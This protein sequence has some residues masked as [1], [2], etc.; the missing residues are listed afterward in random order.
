MIAGPVAVDDTVAKSV[1]QLLL[2]DKNYL[3]DVGKGCDPIFGVRLEFLQG[4]KTT[5]VFF[6]LEC[7][8]L[9]VYVNG[10]AVGSED[11]DDMR[12]QLVKAMQKIFPDD[13]EIQGLKAER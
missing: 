8:I 7:D 6:C 13:K 3:W 4:D 2:N 5:D 10:Q 1:S 12:P 11:F 9:S